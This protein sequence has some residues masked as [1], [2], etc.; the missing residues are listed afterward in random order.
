M[1]SGVDKTKEV[2]KT[3]CVKIHSE[4][5][6]NIKDKIKQFERDAFDNDKSLIILTGSMLRLG[7]SLPCADIAFN[8]DGV[9]SIYLNYQ[10]SCL[11]PKLHPRTLL[12]LA[13]LLL[14]RLLQL[15]P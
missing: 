11:M 7:V 5:K 13:L 4:D 14:R 6:Y 3:Q 10:T 9:R 15:N 8:F 1:K 2:F 12:L